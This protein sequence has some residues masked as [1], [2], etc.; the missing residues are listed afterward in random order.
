[1]AAGR[2]TSQA[3]SSGRLPS[4]RRISPASLA[5]VVVLPAPWRPTIITTVGPLLAMAILAV[6]PPMSFVS[7]SLT[8]LMTCWAGVRLSSTSEP[9]A[10]SVTEAT[11]S[12][13]TL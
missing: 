5:V 4:C 8:I 1:M 3:A 7:S 2:Y 11:N 6:P 10:R 9:T 12:L 13:T